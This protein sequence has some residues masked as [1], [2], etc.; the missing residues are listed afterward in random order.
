MLYRFLL[1]RLENSMKNSKKEID[2]LLMIFMASAAM[3]SMG[4]KTLPKL[5]IEVPMAT[6][7]VEGKGNEKK[8]PCSA[9]KL[10]TRY[11]FADLKSSDSDGK[12]SDSEDSEEDDFVISDKELYCSDEEEEAD[13]IKGHFRRGKAKKRS[14]AIR[15]R[16]K[17]IPQPSSSA[18]P[19]SENGSQGA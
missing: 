7:I 19:N 13:F 14:K 16:W 12:D 8:R 6:E 9:R 5:K 4:E 15:R 11:P 10:K 1:N 2:C 17:A 18:A 3:G